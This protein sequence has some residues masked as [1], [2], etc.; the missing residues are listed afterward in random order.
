METSG[1]AIPLGY[2]P[3]GKEALGQIDKEMDH[4][5]HTSGTLPNAT[6]V[7]REIHFIN[8]SVELGQLGRLWH[9]HAMK[10]LNMPS[11]REKIYDALLAFSL[12]DISSL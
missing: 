2:A 10:R 7:D 9:K 11:R 12:S 1:L 3:E 5:S 4:Q 8:R 6:D